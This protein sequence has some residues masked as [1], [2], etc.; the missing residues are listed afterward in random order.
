M[1]RWEQFQQYTKTL[2]KNLRM[3]DKELAG[4]KVYADWLKA[5][6]ELEEK[7]FQQIVH[8]VCKDAISP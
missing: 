3:M 7:R 2:P 5:I 8:E 1:N 4:A 6:E